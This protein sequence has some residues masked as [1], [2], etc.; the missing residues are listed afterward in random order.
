MASPDAGDTGQFDVSD[1]IDPLDQGIR[2]SLG[3][4]SPL[5]LSSSPSPDP[6]VAGGTND[7]LDPTLDIPLG[8]EHHGDLIIDDD[9]Q[10]A[11]VAASSAAN[12]PPYSDN[13]LQTLQCSDECTPYFEKSLIAAMTACN[14]QECKGCAFC[15]SMMQASQ[16]KAEKE[17]VAEHK[18]AFA[19]KNTPAPELSLSLPPQ[20]SVRL[21]K[22]PK[23][24]R[25]WEAEQSRN[26]RKAEEARRTQKKQTA[27]EEAVLLNPRQLK[28]ATDAKE[29]ELSALFEEKLAAARVAAAALQPR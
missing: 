14:A 6:F 25:A 19:A 16:H 29:R 1:T 21:S 13:S 17:V 26:N 18:M 2:E 22:G 10:A 27:K 4:A 3:G 23:A 15:A 9:D 20:R 12:G 5:P 28:Q 7:V 11:E 24:Q 8:G